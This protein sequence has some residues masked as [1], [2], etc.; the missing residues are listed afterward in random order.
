MS[1]GETGQRLAFQQQKTGEVDARQ[2]LGVIRLSQVLN[3]V[4][5]PAEKAIAPIRMAAGKCQS[6]QAHVLIGAPVRP[7][8]LKET[9]SGIH[10]GAFVEEAHVERRLG[11]VLETR[12]AERLRAEAVDRADFARVVAEQ[13]DVVAVIRFVG[14]AGEHRQRRDF[15]VSAT[16]M[17]RWR[18]HG[19]RVCSTM[20]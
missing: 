17:K 7:T 2:W 12:I 8:A 18:F 16:T 5:A 14:G 9:G 15:F 11:A 3:V 1:L 6:R 20:T 13:I 4:Q 19:E 10:H